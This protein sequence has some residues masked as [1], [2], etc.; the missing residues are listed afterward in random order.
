MTLSL[1]PSTITVP[2]GSSGTVRARVGEA[3]YPSPVMIYGYPPAPGFRVFF[4][5]AKYEFPPWQ[6]D[7]V[8]GVDPDV[9]EGIYEVRIYAYGVLAAEEVSQP[10]TVNVSLA[11]PAKAK[12]IVA[13]LGFISSIFGIAWISEK[14]SLR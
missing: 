14:L 9:P 12:A 10:L 1:S 13:A 4:P 3:G 7:V 2:P 8:I 5:D 6:S 11:V